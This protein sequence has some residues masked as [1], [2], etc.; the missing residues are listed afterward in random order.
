MKVHLHPISE[1]SVPD[2]R[3]RSELGDID[4]LAASIQRVGLINP[5]T[6]KSDGTL[7]AGERRLTALVQLGHSEAPCRYYEDLSPEDQ[8]LIELDENIK[9]KQ[10]TWQEEARAITD[11]H[12]LCGSETQEQTA[13]RIGMSPAYIS[14]ALMVARE[15]DK[16]ESRIRGA[17]SIRSAYNI[18]ARGMQRLV[19]TELSQLIEVEATVPVNKEDPLP[20]EPKVRSAKSDIKV[21]SFLEFASTYSGRK[22][23]FLHCDFPYGIGHHKSEQGGR[24][25]QDTY[26]D[27]PQTYWRLTKALVEN[28]D[29]LLFPSAH[30]IFWFSKTHEET[31]RAYINK[32]APSLEIFDHPLIWH[33][34]DNKG[35]VSDPN[36]RPRH[37]YET[38][39]FMSRGDRHIVKVKSDLYPCPTAGLHQ[40]AKP[41]PMLKHFFE[42]VVDDMSEV[43][44]PTCGGGSS[45]CAAEALGAKRV[46][47]MDINPD[48][49]LDAQAALQRQ[50]QLEAA[51]QVV[52]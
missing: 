48:F 33:K 25:R 4:G 35:I 34:S 39:L 21:A 52:L 6:I 7:I 31:T 51:A 3:D 50:R 9:R 26:I 10:L 13:E 8:R 5:L 12:R 46:F 15:L 38:A 11:F 32:N 23:N 2:R 30:V 47:G 18:I 42:M 29:R 27:D 1:I 20:A 41:V 24:D 28:L 16:P 43:L 40:S 45:L 49:V 22:F 14:N 37:V 17:S 36:R 19:D 44:D